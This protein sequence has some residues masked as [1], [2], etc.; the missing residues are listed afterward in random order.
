[1]SYRGN[2]TLIS[3]QK[4]SWKVRIELPKDNLSGKR[5]QKCYTVYGN[6]SDAEKF[7]TEKLRELDTGLLIDTKKMK[8][9]EYLDYWKEKTFKNL[10][11]TTEEGY[12]QKIEKHIKPYLGNLYLENIKP[13]HLQNF[14]D[15]L[16]LE[17]RLDNKGGLSPR[18]VL[19]IH[20]IIYSSLCQA[21]KWQ[22]VIRNVAESVEPPKAKRYKASYLTDEQTEKLLEVAKRTDI[23]IPIAIAVYTGARRGEVL[24]LNWSNVNLDKGYIRIIDNLCATKKG[25]IIKQ[26]K[27]NNSVRTI[28]ISKT[29]IDLLKKHRIKQLE[30]KMLYGKDYQDNN[31]VCCYENGQFFNPKRFSGKFNELLRKNNL[32]VIRFHDLRHSHA[33]LLVKLGVQPKEISERLGHSNIGITMDLYSHLYEETDREVAEM[34]EQL[35]KAN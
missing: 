1:M 14:Y 31:L 2:I 25:L 15:K 29:L 28:A 16:L 35:I 7:L 34:F 22:L 20:R 24:G 23:Y 10:E 12:I 27:T 3:K 19:A 18:T 9:S 26:P 13:L 32:P 17:G 8:Y 5:K 33:S 4:K 6:K 21:V 11:V 30:N